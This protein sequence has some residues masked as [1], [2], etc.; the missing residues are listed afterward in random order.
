MVESCQV[1]GADVARGWGPVG[2]VRFLFSFSLEFFFKCSVRFG[3]ESQFEKVGH[4]NTKFDFETQIPI[5]LFLRWFQ[6][7]NS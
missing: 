6:H 3:M 5:P 4:P 7:F 1:D 2:S